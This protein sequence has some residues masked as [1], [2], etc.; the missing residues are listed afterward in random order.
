MEYNDQG[1]PKDRFNLSF[2]GI[3]LTS[4]LSG[5]GISTAFVSYQVHWKFSILPPNPWLVLLFPKELGKSRIWIVYSDWELKRWALGKEYYSA[6]CLNVLDEILELN[7][8]CFINSLLVLKNPYELDIVS[9]MSND[10]LLLNLLFRILVFSII[11]LWFI[12]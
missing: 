7:P 6:V 3:S 2:P 5:L 4:Y 8:C 12:I 10:P 1:P 11:L 9:L